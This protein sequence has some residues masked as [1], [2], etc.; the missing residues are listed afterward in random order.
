MGASGRASFEC[1]LQT[2]RHRTRALKLSLHLPHLS[3]KRTG[4]TEAVRA[5]RLLVLF[6]CLVALGVA[7]AEAAAPRDGTLS[8]RD[9]QGMVEVS[10]RG[11]FI[12][13]LERGKITVTDRNPFDAR[14]PVVLGAER[15]RTSRNLRTTTYSGREMRLRSTGAFVHIRLEGRGINL[16]AVGRGRGLIQGVPEGSPGAAVDGLWSLNDEEYLSLP[17]ILTGFQLVAPPPEP[18]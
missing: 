8:V 13:R 3:Q 5:P 11:A 12:G 10:A 15:K 4:H 16:S 1:S 6:A 9:G 14:R 18:R 17:E 7:P 2:D